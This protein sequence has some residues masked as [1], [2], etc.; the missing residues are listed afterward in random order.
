MNNMSGSGSSSETSHPIKIDSSLFSAEV[1][2][3][4]FDSLQE[5]I[6]FCSP[7]R[8]DL[9]WNPSSL[10]SIGYRRLFFLV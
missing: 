1:K 6:C 9:L 7:L 4:G 5:Q 8:A 10:L 2:N 3:A